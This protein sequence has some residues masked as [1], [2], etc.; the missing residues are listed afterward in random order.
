MRQIPSWPAGTVLRA[1]HKGKVYEAV[2][3]EPTGLAGDAF[4]AEYNGQEYKSLSAM[5]TAVT[6]GACNG[7]KFWKANG[8]ESVA[9]PSRSVA[10]RLAVQR[11]QPRPDFEQEQQ[12]VNTDE[13]PDAFRVLDGYVPEKPDERGAYSTCNPKLG[14][15]PDWFKDDPNSYLMQCPGCDLMVVAASRRKGFFDDYD[16]DVPHECTH[17][18]P[19]ES[20]E[21]A[22]RRLTHQ[23]FLF[24]E[25][26]TRRKACGAVEQV[27]DLEDE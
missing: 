22:T 6:G 17:R 21:E 16:G 27:A 4:R 26:E 10:R 23:W 15:R 8:E 20:V 25:A 18:K 3:L 24:K 9:V 11:G 2:V 7:W 19:G 13:L 1:R 12:K 5:G 14:P